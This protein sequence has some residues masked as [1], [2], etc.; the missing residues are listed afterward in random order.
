MMIIPTIFIPECVS[1]FFILI[2]GF[3]IILQH[4]LPFKYKK[5]SYQTI[6]MK[7]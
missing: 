3:N 5:V 2:F 7:K 1:D 4:T 6:K